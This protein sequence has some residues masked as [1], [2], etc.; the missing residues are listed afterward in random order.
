MVRPSGLTTC[1]AIKENGRSCSKNAHTLIT[2]KVKNAVG[3]GYSTI[4]VARCWEH[5]IELENGARHVPN[6]EVVEA[7]LLE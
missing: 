5:Y 2:V 6:L 7:K 4:E 3:G 1:D